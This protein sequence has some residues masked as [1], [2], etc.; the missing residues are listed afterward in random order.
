ME[1]NIYVGTSTGTEKKV[2]LNL[3]YPETNGHTIL[4]GESGSGKTYC[5]QV[6]VSELA[7]AGKTVYIL[8]LTGSLSKNQVEPDFFDIIKGQLNYVNVARDGLQMNLFER[9][10]M[11]EETLEKDSD[12]AGR[13]IDSLTS[14]I[15][16]GEI[17]RALLYEKIKMMLEYCNEIGGPPSLELLS[18]ILSEERGTT[19]K[20]II[21][22]MMQL[23]DGKYFGVSPSQRGLKNCG[24]IKL[25]QMQSVPHGIQ[26]VLTDLI[27]WQ[28][29]SHAV[30][31]GSKD[32]PQYILI[33]EFQ[34]V[35][36]RPS[37]PLYK[38]LCEGRKFGLNLILAT[39]FFKCKFAEEVE[40]AV[41]QIGN[42]LFF[43]PPDREAKFIA[44]FLTQDSTETK[45]YEV[46][47]RGLRKGEAMLK[48]DVY[49]D[50][51]DCKRCV[52]PIKVKIKRLKVDE[53]LKDREDEA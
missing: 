32:N 16:K 12:L 9:I 14:C 33:D 44:G 48:G 21:S 30:Q 42:K 7:K 22:K 46:K 8:D 10:M 1:N 43:R 26:K 18:K 53:K 47:L 13:M 41:A 39:Q 20:K 17:Q 15:G 52:R 23:T 50:N 35:R 11:D 27:L 29:W 45:T 40:M 49:F 24:N 2:Y 25:M 31:S 4:L 19:P 34:N 6:L 28:I 37:S 3:D 5:T 38:I 51:I 36:L